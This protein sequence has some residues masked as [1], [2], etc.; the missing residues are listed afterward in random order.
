[1]CFR[2]C[3]AGLATVT[4]HSK[5]FR[6]IQKYFTKQGT[7]MC[8]IAQW[9]KMTNDNLSALKMEIK[10][11]AHVLIKRHHA[12]NLSGETRN[13]CSLSPDKELSSSLHHL[14]QIVTPHYFTHSL[15]SAVCKWRSKPLPTMKSS[16]RFLISY[17]CLIRN[18]KESIVLKTWLGKSSQ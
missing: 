18:V 16:K 5:V 6:Y 9:K 11:V 14:V 8:F 7:N 12:H 15:E 1:M 2:T 4:V 3:R 13:I 10:D 17:M